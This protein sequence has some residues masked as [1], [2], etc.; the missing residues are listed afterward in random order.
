MIVKKT[1][2]HGKLMLCENCR[3]FHLEFNNLL[4]TIKANHFKQFK[5]YFL[6]LDGDYWEKKNYKSVY[7]RKIMVPVNHDKLTFMLNFNELEELKELLS[8]KTQKVFEI[9]TNNNFNNKLSLN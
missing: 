6:N 8:D 7:R 2:Q 5:N 1:T 9:T 4:F 3:A